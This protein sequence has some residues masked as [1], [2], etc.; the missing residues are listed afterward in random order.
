MNHSA[1]PKG[2]TVLGVDI[3]GG[4]RDEAVNT[5]DTRLGKLAATPMRLSVGGK[6]EKL[7][8]D[9]AGLTLD[10]QATVRNA[11]GSDYNPVSVIGSLFGGKRIVEPVIPVDE[12]KLSVALTDLAGVSG[13]A[14]EGTIRF[15]PGKAVAVPGKA[16]ESL[17]VKRSMLSVQDAYRAQVQTGKVTV[18]EL[19][20]TTRQPV[21]S[22][23]EI[24][25]AMKEFA[26]PAMSDLV[27][28]QAGA[29]RSSSVPRGPSPRSCP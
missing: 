29:S 6:T 10:S 4:T 9:K 18:V 7:P 16:G 21:I 8:P 19:P 2:T 26:E 27:T 22:Q 14:R 3:G 23:A 5:L 28:I 17:D 20:V 15:E 12:E 25:R 24:D 11:A 13:S 1:V